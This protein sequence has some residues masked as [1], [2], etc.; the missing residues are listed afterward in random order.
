VGHEPGEVVHSF[1][2]A[3]IPVY[4]RHLGS[5][6]PSRSQHRRY[7]HHLDA[8]VAEGAFVQAH[9]QFEVKLLPVLVQEKE[10]P[11]RA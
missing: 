10:G 2:K 6:R 1:A 11:V 9:D 4:I 3:P 5:V 7:P 8:N